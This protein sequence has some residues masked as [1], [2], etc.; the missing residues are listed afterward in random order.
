LAT[1]EVH[2]FGEV[3]AGQRLSRLCG[4]QADCCGHGWDVGCWKHFWCCCFANR[5]GGAV[6]RSGLLAI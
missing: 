1:E 6:R 4:G 2:A 3:K 5:T